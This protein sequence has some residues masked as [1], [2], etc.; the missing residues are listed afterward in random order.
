MNNYVCPYQLQIR[1]TTTTTATATTTTTTT[2]TTT[3]TTISHILHI[4][5]SLPVN[6][7]VWGYPT[8][9]I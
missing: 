7:Q 9:L 1:I 5:F 8:M 4:P 3:T 2:I 6:G